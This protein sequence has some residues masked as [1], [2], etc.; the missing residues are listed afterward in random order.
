MKPTHPAVVVALDCITGLQ[1]ARI[2]AARG[3]PVIG[4]AAD[5]RHFCART[6]AVQRVVE[7]PTS[8][9][10]L[11]AALERLGPE[12]G[13]SAGSGPA[14]LVPCS[15]AAVL[16]ISA[17]RERLAPWYRIVLPAHDTVELLMDKIRFTEHAQ[18]NDLAIPPSRIL[19]DRSDA[20]AAAAELAYPAVVK[21][22]LKTARWQAAT[23]AKVFRVEDAA[24]LLATYDRCSAWADVL[25]AQEWIA[26]GET[27]LYSANVYFDRASEPQV[28]FIARKIR[29]W[30]VETGT[31]C[32]GEEVRNDA[33]LAESVRLFESVAYQGL[34]YLEMKRDPRSGRHF[35]IEPNIGRPTG[36]SAIAER[37]GVELVM[38]AYR[39]ALGEPLPAD[40][41][42]RYRAV[43]WIYWRH[44]LQAS[45]VAAR[46]GELS[47]RGWWRSVLGPK[48]EAV[49]SWRDPMPFLIDGWR[50]LATGA[51]RLVRRRPSARPD[52]G[53]ARVKA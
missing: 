7:G 44:D 33:V 19:R 46:R 9:D 51:A 12:L 27:D 18:A 8:G 29:Q 48:V 34:G 36:R 32:L 3:V 40:R 1:T 42:Q 39:D 15:D 2:L 47:L 11:I 17:G 43:K 21:P 30:P 4:L 5:R 13:D 6:R 35:I 14:V 52:P 41:T 50:T 45:L 23:K 37:G 26:G 31:S 22:G 49:G 24:E 53:Q 20:V 38:T 25:I 28:T 16:A 10:G